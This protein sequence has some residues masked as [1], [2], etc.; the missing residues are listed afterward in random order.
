MKQKILILWLMLLVGASGLRAA[1]AYA[2]HSIDN[3]TLTFYCDNQKNVRGGVD[4]NTIVEHAL[5]VRDLAR[6]QVF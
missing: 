2:V 4:L 3:T 5:H 1:Q 6:V